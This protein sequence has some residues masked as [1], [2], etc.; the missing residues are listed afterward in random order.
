LSDVL[1]RSYS[2][3]VV[4]EAAAATAI[5]LCVMDLSIPPIR[6][7]DNDGIEIAYQVIGDAGPVFMGL[8][9]LAQNI[10]LMWEE[11]RAARFLRRLGSFCR[12]I[13]F[14][15]RGTGLSGRSA[16]LSSFPDRV[17]DLQ[18]VMDAEGVEDAF[19]GGFSEGGSMSALFAA[20]Y[21]ERTRGLLLIS[22]TASFTRHTDLP[23][24]PS[25]EDLMAM[26]AQWSAAWGQGSFTTRLL[27]PSMAA[28]S[29]YLRWMARY[30]RQALTPSA[31]VDLWRTNVEIDVRSLLGSIQAPTVVIHRREEA[32]DTRNAEYLASAIA[33]ARLVVLDGADH[34][35]WIGD[36]DAV[37]DEMEDL[38]TGGRR[39]VPSE[40]VLATVMFTDIVDSTAVASR[41]GDAAWRRLLDE[42][43]SQTH[44]AVR[45][46]MGRVVK[47]T[48]DGVLA[49]FESPS[50]AMESAVRLRNR[51]AEIGI[52]I[53]AGL[54]TGEIERRGEDVGG[55]GVH[56]AARI[57]ALAGAGQIVVS[58]TV[59]DLSAGSGFAF[60]D[61]GFSKLKGVDGEWRVHLLAG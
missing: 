60:E 25:R 17:T 30:E 32:I 6:Y 55:V 54:H 28:D 15:K 56:I 34:L 49:T 18:A 50:R 7:A 36:Q 46:G 20:S 51:L 59:K 41:L 12:M 13:H 8:P 3:A 29:E 43:D 16:G 9:G 37:I 22:T 2:L 42:H 35:P 14:D 19:I 53:R 4:R 5:T 10:E 48:G 47:S 33:G 23:W 1:A 52:E 39:V 57:E 21:P 31:L 27:A 45:D 26:A 11:P 58:S 24:N 44:A 40:R 38:I 61:L